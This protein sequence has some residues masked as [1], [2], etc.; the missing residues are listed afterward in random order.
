[1]NKIKSIFLEACREIKNNL[2]IYL[3]GISTA[4]LIIAVIFAIPM[5]TV[6]IESTATYN[7]VEKITEPYTEQEPYIAYSN[8]AN[9]RILV[10]GFYK[11]VPN[12]T[13]V[14][15][16]ID[17]PD[18]RVIGQFENSIP[19]RFAILGI[20][21]RVIWETMGSRDVIDLPLEPGQYKALFKEDV[22]WGEDCYIFLTVQ[23][24]E[25]EPVIEYKEVTKYREVEVPVEKQKTIESEIRV[26]L[27]NY[28]FWKLPRLQLTV[29]Q[30]G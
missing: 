10:N 27:W 15:F 29:S 28:I 25:S 13:T 12:G 17:K 26:S 2:K 22:M 4:V 6:T 9:T 23:W 18:S 16:T 30:R 24:G 11:V 20:G 3:A 5:K 21:D 19:G 1:M 8:N 14:P 7:D